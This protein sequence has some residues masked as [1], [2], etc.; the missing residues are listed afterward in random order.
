M[1]VKVMGVRVVVV[2]G[3][4]VNEDIFSGEVWSGGGG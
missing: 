1:S 4:G 3:M 2:V